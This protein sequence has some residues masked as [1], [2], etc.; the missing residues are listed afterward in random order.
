MDRAPTISVCTVPSLE[1]VRPRDASNSNQPDF[2][3]TFSFLFISKH[4]RQSVWLL[5]GASWH[6]LSAGQFSNRLL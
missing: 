6:L 5:V 3:I 2:I 4:F 1:K